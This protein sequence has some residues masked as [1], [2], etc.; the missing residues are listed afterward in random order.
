MTPNTFLGEGHRNGYE[1]IPRLQSPSIVKK[2]VK[3]LTQKI[4]IDSDVRQLIVE[5]Q[6][7]GERLKFSMK[8]TPSC[9]DA[10]VLVGSGRSGTTWLAQVLTHAHG[11]QQIFE[12]LFPVWNKEV[13]ALTGWDTADPY[14]RAKYLRPG[15]SYPLWNDLLYR[16]LIGQYRNY[17][18]DYERN[19]YFPNHF[20]IKEIRANLMLGYLCDR[21]L[22]KII[23]V[24]RHPCAVVYSRLS[25]PKTWYADVGDILNQEDLVEDHLR[26]WVRKMEKV[27]DV[28]QAH[29]VWWAV[30]NFVA[31]QHL[32]NYSHFFVTY[33][34]VVLEPKRKAKEMLTWLDIS[35]D[36]RKLKNAVA[37]PSRMMHNNAEYGSKFGPLSK[38]KQK[39]PSEDQS[40]ILYWAKELGIPYYNE[41]IYPLIEPDVIRK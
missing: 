3:L 20:L 36:T 32:S 15:G 2:T 41:D 6:M 24:M 8:G 16:I 7:L 9:S 13:R 22:P 1:G 23:Y 35:P 17:W 33:E 26:P 34:E 12:P 27:T 11:I 37:Q 29:A 10:I 18:T 19:S 4:K 38:W 14:V 40:R 30:E 39:L 25:A 21:F 5:I 31:L 28:L